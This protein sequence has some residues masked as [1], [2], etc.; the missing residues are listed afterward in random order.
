MNTPFLKAFFLPYTLNPYLRQNK[1]I[2]M[3]PSVPKFIENR[4]SDK[5]ITQQAKDQRKGGKY[6]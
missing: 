4:L 3:K 5:K 2:L 1:N 6:V